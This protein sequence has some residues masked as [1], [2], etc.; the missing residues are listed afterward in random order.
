VL[1]SVF[2]NISVVTK[3]AAAE[4]VLDGQPPPPKNKPPRTPFVIDFGTLLN[5]TYN[6]LFSTFRFSDFFLWIYPQNLFIS[7]MVLIKSTGCAKSA[8]L[9]A[10]HTGGDSENA[11]RQSVD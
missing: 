2:E 9:L 5:Q 11:F 6:H 3:K 4:T 10:Q 8:N 7:L 1:S